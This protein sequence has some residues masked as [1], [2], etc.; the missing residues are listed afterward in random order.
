MNRTLINSLDTINQLLAVC[1]II[2][3]T[4]IAFFYGRVEQ[5]GTIN[6]VVVFYT[7]VGFI[8]GLVT[9]SVVCGLLATLIEIERHLRGLASQKPANP[10]PQGQS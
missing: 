9:A 5:Y 1:L 2:G 7:I 6:A 8:G 10:V 3:A 4:L